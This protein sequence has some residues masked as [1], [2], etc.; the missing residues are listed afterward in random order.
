MHSSEDY[1]KHFDNINYNILSHTIYKE[2]RYII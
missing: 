2:A 1:V